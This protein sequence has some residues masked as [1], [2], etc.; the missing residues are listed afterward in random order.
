MY[1]CFEGLLVAVNHCKQL[2]ETVPL[3]SEQASLHLS[4]CPPFLDTNGHEVC[5]TCTDKLKVCKIL[6][7][8]CPSWYVC[9]VC[10]L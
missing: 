8:I 5:Q 6:C 4:S 9:V 7:S 10:R 3:S 1:Q 2:L